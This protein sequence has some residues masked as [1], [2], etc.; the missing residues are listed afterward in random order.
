MTHADLH[1]FIDGE[2]L[3]SAG[4]ETRPV[5]NP[6]TGQPLGE[7]PL[8]DATDLDR[9]L[10]AAARAFPGWRATPPFVRAQILRR[11]AGLIRERADAIARLMVLEEGKVLAEART[12]LAV[13]ADI[14]DWC[15]EEGRRT[16]GRVIPSRAPGLAQVALREP[17]GPVAGLS[18]WNA[19]ALMPARMAAEALAAGC[20]CI[21]KPAE[22]A[23]G[24]ALEVARACA[25]AGL[26]PGVLGMVFGVPAEVSRHL[27]ASPV[28]RKVS[29]TG[30]VEVGRQLGSLAGAHVKPITLELG[31]HAPVMV[32]ADA[33]LERAADLA[34][35]MKAR[36]AGQLCGSP[37]RFLVE[38]P[39]HERFLR[40]YAERAAAIRLGD[41]LDPA[42]QMGPLAHARRLAAMESFVADAE[43][44]GARVE[45]GGARR[46]GPGFFFAPTVLSGL[47]PECALMNREPFGPLSAFLSFER[48]EEAI[49]EANRLP[50]GLAAYAFTRS[51][52][53]AAALKEGLEA[54]AVG[55]NS[56]AVVSPETPFGGVKE[57]G[58]GREGGI[59]GIAACMVTKYVAEATN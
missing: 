18:P 16:Y 42:S 54:G 45:T 47:T 35:A 22:E 1:L 29:F 19:P 48:L 32:F 28:I 20:T 34:I 5:I 2:R 24:T 11:A 3:G 4:R 30:S 17:I 41:G 12:E 46:A 44:K 52:A 58:Y 33:D 25:D 26:P 49:A 9:A 38:A 51:A 6:A 10:E 57:S 40:L 13:T 56:F 15:A 31:G 37:T 8:A 7:L 14:I 39:V 55:I 27:I 59:E 23:P 36:N 21:L 50:Y 43:A 53:T